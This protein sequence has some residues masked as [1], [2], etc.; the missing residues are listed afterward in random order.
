MKTL[1]ERYG[2]DKALILALGSRAWQSIAGLVSL[3][4]VLRYFSSEL[5][6]YHYTFLGI[7]AAQGLFEL[8]LGVAA[9]AVISHEWHRYSQAT[10][11]KGNDSVHSLGDVFR[12]VLRWYV[13]A[14]IAFLVCGGLIGAYFL[15]QK[16][17]SGVTWGLPWVLAIIS[18]SLGLISS[19]MLSMLDGC[20]KV[21]SIARIRLVQSVLSNAGFW[22]A[23][24]TGAELWSTAVLLLLNSIVAFTLVYRLHGPLVQSL[25]NEK[26]G[27]DDS[28]RRS[29][30]Q[31]QWPLAIQ[32]ASGFFMFAYFVPAVF[33]ARG[34]VEAGQL[35]MSLQIVTTLTMLAIVP[36]SIR[37]PALA[38]SV[39][40]GDRVFLEASWRQ[41][42]RMSLV[43]YCLLSLG[44]LLV[45][46]ALHALSW[47][48]TDRFLDM[49]AFRLLAT[50]GLMLIVVQ[51][52]A[53]YWRAHQIE[54]L[55]AYSVLPGIAAALGITIGANSNG[56][57]GAILGALASYVTVTIPLAIWGWRLARKVRL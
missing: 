16:P 48:L 37:M 29:I 5:Q 42:F 11:T 13:L 49:D 26:P 28:W 20:Q 43:I 55:G 23:V 35:G 22:V 56:A 53:T 41:A 4:L 12:Y 17:G 19:G 33:S 18:A 47:E 10:E 15:G 34:A 24:V 6:G 7:V 38:L 50:W 27:R 3:F 36:L 44:F 57:S 2:I 25:I 32:A 1:L 45:L 31:M 46:S 9:T 54:P 8:G 30:T 14:A 51:G 39:A 21:E 52:A 40:R